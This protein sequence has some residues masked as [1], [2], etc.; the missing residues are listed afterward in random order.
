MN[1]FTS[2]IGTPASADFEHHRRVL[3]LAN[4]WFYSDIRRTYWERSYDAIFEFLTGKSSRTKFENDMK[5]AMVEAFVAAAEQAWQDAGAELP[6]DEDTSAYVGGVQSGE[7]GYISDLFEHLLL[8][9][10]ELKELAQFTA[11][12]TAAS[13]ADGYAHT[14]DAVYAN[15]KLLAKPNVMLTFAGSDGAESCSDCSRLKG[16]R[17]RAKWWV[18]NEAVPPSRHFECKGYRC[19]HVLVTDEGN[20]YT[21]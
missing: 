2:T 20:L 10:K 1:G 16:K 18:A 3:E 4:L 9:R 6:Y 11:Q 14:L 19:Q 15:V 12:D 13:R 21:I 8:L 17:H 5:K 7:L